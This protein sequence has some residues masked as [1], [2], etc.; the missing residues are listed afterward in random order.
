MTLNRI[1]R[2]LP[3][4]SSR[5][6]SKGAVKLPCLCNCGRLTGGRFYPGHDGTLQRLVLDY[7]H[8]LSVPKLHLGVVKIEAALRAAC[9]LTKLAHVPLQI[10]R[11]DVK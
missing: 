7:E 8:S 2:P 9:G 10:T 5:T 1:V 4:R 6:R 11:D 3:A